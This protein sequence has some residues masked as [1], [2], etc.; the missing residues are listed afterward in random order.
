[1]AFF[2]FFCLSQFE[3][4]FCQMQPRILTHKGTELS[5]GFGNVVTAQRDK[6]H[7]LQC[8]PSDCPGRTG[9][10]RRA[11][12]SKGRQNCQ[13]VLCQAT[14]RLVGEGQS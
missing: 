9:T 3:V 11:V 1:M 7:N 8:H 13:G 12:K 10:P 2:F 5:I 4:D 6:F 14:D